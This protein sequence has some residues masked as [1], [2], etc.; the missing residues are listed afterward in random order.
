MSATNEELEGC[1]WTEWIETCK[2]VKIPVR[3][4]TWEYVKSLVCIP[5]SRDEF[6]TVEVLLEEKYENVPSDGILEH[7]E[8]RCYVYEKLTEESLLILQNKVDSII[9]LWIEFMEK[10]ENLLPISLEFT[11]DKWMDWDF[12]VSDAIR[13]FKDENEIYPVVLFLSEH[14]KS[15][16]EFVTGISPKSKIYGTVINEFIYSDVIDDKVETCKVKF[17]VDN[18]IADK[19]F[20]LD[21]RY[22][23]DDDDDD[24]RDDDFS[25]LEPIDCGVEKQNKDKY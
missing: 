22:G 23:Y 15:Q 18:K 4:E 21:A 12:T 10:E 14:T 1:S 6:C 16:I 2:A 19:H 8:L 20:I 3:D 24:N 25:P 7:E 11:F 17:A 5:V 9:D 13:K